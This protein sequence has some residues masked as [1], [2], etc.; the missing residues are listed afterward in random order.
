MC[1]CRRVILDNWLTTNETMLLFK[2]KGRVITRPGLI[3]IG[4]KKGWARKQDDNFHWEF[5]EIE[6]LKYL[7]SYEDT[8]GFCAVQE[9]AKDFDI[10]IGKVYRIIKK[11]SLEFRRRKNAYTYRKTDFEESYEEFLKNRYKHY[12][13]R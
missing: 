3:E 11:Y 6:V 8:E 10:S 2:S 7:E 9:L 12:K 5:E 1:G 13:K 4:L